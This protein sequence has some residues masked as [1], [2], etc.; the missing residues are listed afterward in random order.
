LP[1]LRQRRDDLPALVD[2]FVQRFMHLSAQY[3]QQQVRVSPEAMELLREHSWPGNLD[4][5]QS[6]LQQT[7]IE[8]TGT[9]LAS[10]SLLH[11]L[12]RT[13]SETSLT[14]QAPPAQSYWQ[15]FVSDG[16]A[17]S[18]THLYSEAIADMERHMVA[19]VLESTS[20]NQ[21]RAARIL[22]IT[23]GNLRKKLRALGLVPNS[24]A[25]EDSAAEETPM[26]DSEG[27]SS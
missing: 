3:N 8:N 27:H 4:E 24:I 23:R 15:Q 14:A 25:E 13:N 7:L 26:P 22:G 1:P 11:S 17:R 6:V 5:L 16:L 2:H 19:L 21:A 10:S 12:R 9:V 20:G 18:S